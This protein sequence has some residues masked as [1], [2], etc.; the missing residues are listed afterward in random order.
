MN[1]ATLANQLIFTNRLSVGKEMVGKGMVGK[2][3]REKE[4]EE[5]GREE[6]RGR[7]ENIS[8]QQGCVQQFFLL[9]IRIQQA[10]AAF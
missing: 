2:G 3:R 10:A 6:R 7:E 1:L 4:R 9:P 5:K 8:L